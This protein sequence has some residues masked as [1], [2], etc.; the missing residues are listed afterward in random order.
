MTR[1]K[2][3]V[4][5]EKTDSNGVRRIYGYRSDGTVVLINVAA[6]LAEY[7]ARGLKGLE[8]VA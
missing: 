2:Y 6:V 3:E 1:K 5:E 7:R 4:V 8:V